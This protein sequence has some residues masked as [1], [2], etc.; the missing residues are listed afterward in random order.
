MRELP[1]ERK[2]QR[3]EMQIVYHREK[4]PMIDLNICPPWILTISSGLR[5]KLHNLRRIVGSYLSEGMTVIDIGCGM[6]YFA[7]PMDINQRCGMAR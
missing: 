3:Q 7:I 6:G 5:K 2:L 4:T 1:A